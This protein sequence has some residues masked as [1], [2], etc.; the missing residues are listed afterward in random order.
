MYHFSYV[1]DQWLI[2]A[3]G[4]GTVLTLLVCLSYI[5][6][7]RPRPPEAK[8]RLVRGSPRALQFIDTKLPETAGASIDALTAAMKD[9]VLASGEIVGLGS[10]DPNAPPPARRGGPGGAGGA[11]P[12]PAGR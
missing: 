2:L 1:N 9:H 10:V 7:W 6:I 5:A 12:P 8:G 3:L 11:T 4:G